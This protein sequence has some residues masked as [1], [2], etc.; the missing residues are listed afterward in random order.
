MDNI[1]I[2]QLPKQDETVFVYL[3]LECHGDYAEIRA[4]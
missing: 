4:L 3:G 2:I 1:T